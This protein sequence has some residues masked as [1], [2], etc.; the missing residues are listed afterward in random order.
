MEFKVI[1]NENATKLDAIWSGLGPYSQRF[2]ARSSIL[3]QFDKNMSKLLLTRDLIM[4]SW[5]EFM[6]HYLFNKKTTDT[7]TK[8]AKKLLD[9]T[10]VPDWNLKRKILNSK[11]QELEIIILK[12]LEKIN[13]FFK[14]IIGHEIDNVSIFLAYSADG[15]FGFGGCCL[16][17]K[18]P[19]IM[20]RLCKSS[21]ITNISIIVHELMHLAIRNCNER[22]KLKTIGHE[23][24]EALFDLLCAMFQ[25]EN[26]IDYKKTIKQDIADRDGYHKKYIYEIYKMIKPILNGKE[27]LVWKYIDWEKLKAIKKGEKNHN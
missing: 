15:E 16:P 23:A 24:E 9:K 11:K 4:G 6:S 7:N 8:L 22:N 26:K 21:K 5:P 3:F 27:D 1:I 2:V 12:N 14:N 18:E 13:F 25:N 17:T 19:A 10:K 20:L